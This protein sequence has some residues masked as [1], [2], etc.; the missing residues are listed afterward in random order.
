MKP[1]VLVPFALLL[2]GVATSAAIAQENPIP[3]VSADTQTETVSKIDPDPKSFDDMGFEELNE[4]IRKLE[5]ELK[6]HSSLGSGGAITEDRIRE[7]RRAN[8]LREQLFKANTALRKKGS[9]IRQ[10]E[11]AKWMGHLAE[12]TARLDEMKRERF[13]ILEKFYQTT[14]AKYDIGTVGIDAALQAE[15]DLADAEFDLQGRESY[16][17]RML[18][19]REWQEEIETAKANQGSWEEDHTK[20]KVRFLKTYIEYLK[21][22]E[23]NYREI[24]QR[25]P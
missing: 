12:V 4:V 21:G 7:Q 9:D 17:T 6:D 5:D 1:L 20:V 23:E 15:A 16:K 24:L 3:P 11:R 13:G 14:K 2:G 8:E 18:R 19:L 10:A 25:Y 22:T